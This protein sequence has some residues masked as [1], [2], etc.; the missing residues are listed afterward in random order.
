MNDTTKQ[1]PVVQERPLVT[2]ALFAYNQEKYIKEAIKG[3]FDQ[4][5]I[6]LEIILSDDSSTD[7][8]FEIMREM[9]AKYKGP[10][11]VKVRQNNKNKGLISHINEVSRESSGE[12]VVVAAGDDVSFNDRTSVLM[13]YFFKDKKITAIFSDYNNIIHSKINFQY[14]KDFIIIGWLEH[15]MGLGGCGIGATY[16]YHRSCFFTPNYLPEML[17][18][19]DRILPFRASIL[20]R[21]IHIKNYLVNYRVNTDS[22]IVKFKNEI[23]DLTNRRPHI[24]Y[25]IDELNDF[26]KLGKISKF[27]AKIYQYALEVSYNYQINNFNS[28]HKNYVFIYF[29]QYKILRIARELDRLYLKFIRLFQH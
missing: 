11:H 19:E 16:A 7:R 25:L 26:T 22:E 15:A 5:Y 3:A 14:K 29:L 6:P 18:L 17:F 24:E 20:G 10:H 1:L 21:V 8:T 28:C 2:F 23:T 27:K 12:Y 9:A 4:T 13:N